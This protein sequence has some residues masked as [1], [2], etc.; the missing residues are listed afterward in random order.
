MKHQTHTF[1]TPKFVVYHIREYQHFISCTRIMS[2]HNQFISRTSNS[3]FEDDDDVDY[4]TFLANARGGGGGGGYG[5]GGA[6]SNTNHAS[7]AN[8]RLEQLRMQKQEIEQRTLESS[9]RSLGLLHDTEQVG[10][11]TAEELAKQREQLE[12]TNKQLDLINTTLRSSQKHINGLKSVFGGLKNYLTGQRNAAAAAASTGGTTGFANESPD[13][14]STAHRSLTRDTSYDGHPV[15]RLRS[16]G[17]QMYDQETVPYA[18]GNAFNV[19]LDQN[20]DLMA[21]SLSRLK[22]LA[23]D[24]NQ[25]IE[26][27]NDLIDN[28][29]NKVEDVD[30]KITRQN[31][32]VKKMLK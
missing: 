18:S 19:Q 15:A 9:K 6:N 13:P 23:I 26:S 31:R 7:G 17:N 32:D 29:A 27:Q 10:M 22:G 24:L 28:I 12:N 14:S 11:A 16:D 5:G 21:G 25:D 1:H 20:L 30:V 2:N 8:E 4:D 3:L